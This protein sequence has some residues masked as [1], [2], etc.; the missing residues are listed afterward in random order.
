MLFGKTME[1]YKKAGGNNTIAEIRQQ[2]K[3]WRETYQM[4]SDRKDDIIA[5]FKRNTDP[6]TRIVLTG[7]GTSQYIGDT[8][9]PMLNAKLPCRVE[10]IGTT[11]IVSAPAYY[12]EAETPTILISFARSGNSPE[13]LGAFDLFQNNVENLAQLIVTCAPDGHLAKKAAEIPGS[14]TLFMPEGSNDKGFAMTSSFTCMMLTA[15]LIFKLGHLEDYQTYVNIIAEQADQFM[16]NDYQDV[17][18]LVNY[19]C[20]RLVYLGS[21]AFKGLSEEMALKNL[22]LCSGKIPTMH[23]S[24]MGFRHGPKSFINDET[25]V[26]IAASDDP[27]VRAYDMDLAEEIHHDKGHHKLA[28]ISYEQDSTLTDRCTKPIVLGGEPIPDIFKIFNVVLIAQI[29]AYFNS[30]K[31]GVTPDNPR[32]DGSVNRVV[33]GVILHPY[34][35]EV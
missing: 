20:K 26:I 9:A 17:L 19:G 6:L 28:I 8:I 5:F 24:V 22:E 2:P 30:L 32:P 23:E 18:D 12:L 11:D 3:L 29:F 14:L 4:V 31:Q 35:K 10:S 15:L 33:K 27:Y 1:E 13:S 16:D 7:A 25:L 34:T 21:G